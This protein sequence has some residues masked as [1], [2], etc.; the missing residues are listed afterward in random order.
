MHIVRASDADHDARLN[1]AAAA[2]S[3]FDPVIEEP[4]RAIIEAV[5]SP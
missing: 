3:L 2:S 1:Q 5:R 4:P